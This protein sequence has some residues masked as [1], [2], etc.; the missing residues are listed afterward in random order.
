MAENQDKNK[1]LNS[2]AS[3]LWEGGSQDSTTHGE[4]EVQNNMSLHICRVSVAI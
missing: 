2:P 3:V 1:L 4:K